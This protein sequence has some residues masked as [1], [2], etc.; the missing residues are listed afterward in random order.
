M[1]YCVTQKFAQVRTM[2]LRLSASSTSSYGFHGFLLFVLQIDRMRAMQKGERAILIIVD[3]PPSRVHQDGIALHWSH[4]VKDP[5]LIL[6]TK[7]TLQNYL[8]VTL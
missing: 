2:L 3:N 5:A 4:H 7:E 1:I 8:W 6:R